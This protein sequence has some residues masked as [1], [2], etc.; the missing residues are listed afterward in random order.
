MLDSGCETSTLTVAIPPDTVGIAV[1]VVKLAFAK[2][3]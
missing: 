3:G 2:R 1:T